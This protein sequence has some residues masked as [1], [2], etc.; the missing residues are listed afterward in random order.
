MNNIEKARA[1]SLQCAE[2]NEAISQ[3]KY[4]MAERLI[5][6]LLPFS[7]GFATTTILIATT[8]SVR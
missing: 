4:E 2:K 8:L 1:Y 6:F 3:R 7:I 5:Q